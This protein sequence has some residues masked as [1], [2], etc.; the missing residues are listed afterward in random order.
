ME[1]FFPKPTLCFPDN[2]SVWLFQTEL[3]YLPA[4][5]T[6]TNT[7]HSLLSYLKKAKSQTK[8]KHAKT[9]WGIPWF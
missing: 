5:K 4:S 2:F 9:D 7:E 8:K 3:N 1:H 6:N